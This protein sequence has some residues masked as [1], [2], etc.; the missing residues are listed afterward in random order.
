MNKIIMLN[1]EITEKQQC[2]DFRFKHVK[3]GHA[4]HIGH[5]ACSI[6]PLRKELLLGRL[7]CSEL[8]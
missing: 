5:Q 2:F 7:Y 8:Q 6:P 4:S 1:I 3:V